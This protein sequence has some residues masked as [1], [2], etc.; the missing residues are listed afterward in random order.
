[1]KIKIIILLLVSLLSTG[2]SIMS[3]QNSEGKTDDLGRIAIVPYVSNQVE[4]IP[5]SA[6]NNL[7]SKMAQILSKNDIAGST[8]YPNQFIMVPNVSV[9]SKEVL[10]SA[11]PKVVLNLE[12][13]FYIGDG[14]N[15]VKFGS[16]VVNVKGVGMN[17]N[18]A[19]LSAFRNI[20][21][22]NAELKR[23]IEQSK[24]RILEYYNDG[25]DFILKEAESLANQNEFDQALYVL[26]S[27][28]VVSKDCFNQAQ[29]KI[30][31]IYKKKINRDC[32]ILLNKATNAWNSSQDY[33][34]AKE[35]AMYLNQ[36]EPSSKCYSQVKNLA[37]TIKKGV[38]RN[39]DRNWDFLD[40]Q[41]ESVT[42]IEKTRS[43]TTKEIALYYA[44]SMP[45]NV[46]YNIKGWW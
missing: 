28:P 41:L 18:K 1:M 7:Q 13:A 10:A 37:N 12:V 23:L 44:K 27:V 45:E 36:I 14:I 20:N 40:K 15:G 31:G 26:S 3:A 8:G 4:N 21:I 24:N 42:E 2:S 17:E 43:E 5:L 33:E 32:T 39:I 22:N 29:N 35:S 11:P 25:C 6:K 34:S 46:M 38:T 9:L 16:I 30:E 19:Y